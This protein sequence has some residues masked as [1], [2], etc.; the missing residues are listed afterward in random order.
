MASGSVDKVKVWDVR[1]QVCL[2]DVLTGTEYPVT[3]LRSGEGP[4]GKLLWAGCGDGTIRAF[5]CRMSDKLSCVAT[6]SEHS[7][8]VICIHQSQWHGSGHTLVSGAT[9]GATGTKASSQAKE[10]SGTACFWDIRSFTSPVRSVETGAMTAMAVHNYAPVFACG[11]HKQAIKVFDAAGKELNRIRYHE[12]FLGQRIGPVSCL[13]FHP[14]HSYLAAG[15]VDAYVALF[16][17]TK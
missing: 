3:Y 5:D 13:A 9:G 6:V 12:G 2:Q 7:G 11:S 15:A 1:K 14:H 8:P 16:R 10:T 17:G 4:H